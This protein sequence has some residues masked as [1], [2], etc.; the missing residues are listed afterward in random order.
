MADLLFKEDSLQAR[1]ALHDCRIEASLDLFHFAHERL[2]AN[3]SAS[4]SSTFHL[5]WDLSSAPR[6]ILMGAALL[7]NGTIGGQCT[8]VVNL[9]SPASRA[10]ELQRRVI[11]KMLGSAVRRSS[12]H[13]PDSDSAARSPHSTSKA[14]S[15]FSRTPS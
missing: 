6:K 1:L 8:Y 15:S 2:E 13:G 5:E 7:G 12:V 3:R 9:V 11:L 10:L 4:V 14:F